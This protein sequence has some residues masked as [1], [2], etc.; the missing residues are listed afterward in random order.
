[1]AKKKRPRR[2]PPLKK[3]DTN[4]AAEKAIANIAAREGKTVEQIRLHMNV[5]MMSGLLN[6]DP[7]VKA[8]WANIPRTG[9]VPTPE[10]LIAFYAEQLKKP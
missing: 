10:E 9:E 1:M 2:A 4:A 3:L 6:N 8:N 5:A 7:T